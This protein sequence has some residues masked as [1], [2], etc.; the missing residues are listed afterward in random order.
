MDNYF[1]VVVGNARDKWKE[2]GRRLGL[3]ETDISA[4]D[5]EERGDTT[6]GCR[7][8]LNKWRQ[9]NGHNATVDVLKQ[10]FIELERRDVVDL[11]EQ[12][13]IHEAD[14]G[15]HEA[16]RRKAELRHS[17]PSLFI[18]HAGE[19]KEPFVRP[20]YKA[21]LDQN[22]P[23]EEIFFDEVSISPGENISDKIMSTLESE[24]LKLVTIVVSN[25]LIDKYWPRL[26]YELSLFHQ[27]KF[28]PIWLDQNTDNF[29]AFSRKVGSRFPML[30]KTLA[31]RIQYDNIAE[32]VTDVAVKIV[33][34]L[35]VLKHESSETKRSKLTSSAAASPMEDVTSGTET[36]QENITKGGG[37]REAEHQESAM[38]ALLYPDIDAPGEHDQPPPSPVA[39]SAVPTESGSSENKLKELKIK[40][41]KKRTKDELKML[42]RAK[43]FMSKKEVERKCKE[44][45]RRFERDYARIQGVRDGCLLMYLTFDLVGYLREFWDDYTSGVLSTELTEVLVT[46]EMRAVVGQD[47]FVRVIILERDYRRWERYLERKGEAADPQKPDIRSSRSSVSVHT[48]QAATTP[49]HRLIFKISQELTDKDVQTVKDKIRMDQGEDKMAPYENLSNL[50]EIFKQLEADNYLGYDVDEKVTNALKMFDGL[51]NFDRRHFEMDIE[52]AKE[53]IDFVG[54]EKDMDNLKNRITEGDYG[55][56]K[57]GAFIEIS[58]KGAQNNDEC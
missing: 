16:A 24:S 18:I 56:V 29:E 32:K 20:L 57:Q 1:H 31:H 49:L 47:V 30:K 11:L 2:I 40:R 27:K 39:A 37:E 6:E 55:H 52:N 17:G 45:L 54:R 50:T 43:R 34:L 23:E 25:H 28:H 21:L 36:E 9:M 15:M 46:D 14:E 44:Y 19:D 41:L 53:N 10:A 22:L 35:S 7:K 26:E 3:S 4:I 8:V 51:E 42:G 38:P 48:T 12:A 5:E 33:Q 58:G 13:D